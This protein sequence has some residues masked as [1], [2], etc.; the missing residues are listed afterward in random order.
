MEIFLTIIIA[1]IHQILHYFQLN[2]GGPSLEWEFFSSLCINLLHII[3]NVLSYVFLGAYEGRPPESLG[4]A[5]TLTMYG[6]GL[7]DGEGRPSLS[8][9]SQCIFSHPAAAWAA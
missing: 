5:E 7:I 9:V 6:G 2:F 1:A 8:R 4:K 3:N